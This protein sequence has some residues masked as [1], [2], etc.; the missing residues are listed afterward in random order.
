MSSIS[1]IF[2]QVK[3]T[4]AQTA[5]QV[6]T[7]ANQ[8]KTTVAQAKDQV[9]NNPLTTAATK[10]IPAALKLKDF[11]KD[12]F[13]QSSRL[14]KGL[15]TQGI[16]NK[17]TLSFLS[18]PVHDKFGALQ[19]AGAKTKMAVAGFGIFSAAK[20][21]FTAIKDI[22]DAV[23]TGSREDITK[24]VRSGLT[25][26]RDGLNVV[27]GLQG[28]RVA[29]GIFHAIVNKNKLKAGE[30]AFKAFKNAI[31]NVSDDIA[32]AAAKAARK[33]VFEGIA[34]NS[35][36]ILEAANKLAY[37]TVGKTVVRTVAKDAL[38]E[39]SK[40]AAKAAAQAG[41]KAAA[42]TAA[43]AAGRFAPGVNIAIA[44]IDTA[45]AVAT[46]ADPKASVGKKIT[47]GITA[48]GS[49][50]AATN[51]PIVSQAGAVVSTVSSFVGAFFK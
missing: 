49:I 41:A 20:S 19:L 36:N 25:A 10:G 8:V 15:S 28:S 44:A 51:I 50:A 29:G 22:R 39:G 37:K 11:G 3:T 23:R 35:G 48:V 14:A 45:Q 6:K 30:A 34:K 12:L 21:T 42:G 47:A 27:G 4:V 33:N 1:K 13:V 17:Q 18:N 26:A 9:M 43:K 5:D 46:I 16:L 2:Q 31:P 7:T 32:K 24:A 40:A 38:R